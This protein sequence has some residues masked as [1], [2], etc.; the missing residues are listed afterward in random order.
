MRLAFTNRAQYPNFIDSYELYKKRSKKDLTVD[1][2]TYKR[3]IKTYCRILAARLVDEGLIDLPCDLGSISAVILTRKPQYRGKKFIGY[4]KMNWETGQ[5]DGK[6][7]T[8][9]I[10]YLP[11]RVKYANLRCLGFVANRQL[12]K[13]VKARY[14][15]ED[16]RWQPIEFKDEMI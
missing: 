11:K 6:L 9:G 16:C 5:F 14:V 12:F 4:G 10:T 3:I 15:Q 13:K 8:F 1:Y 2:T 7:K